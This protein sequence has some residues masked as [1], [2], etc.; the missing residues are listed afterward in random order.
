MVYG[1]HGQWDSMRLIGAVIVGLGVI[2]AQTE[3]VRHRMV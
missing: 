1:F 3:P 2:I